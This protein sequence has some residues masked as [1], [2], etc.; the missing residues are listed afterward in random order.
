MTLPLENHKPRGLVADRLLDRLVDGELPN[1][2]RR[3]L[4]LRLESEPDGWRRC[5]LAF[6]ESQSWREA[7]GPLA[8]AAPI[9]SRPIRT[10]RRRRSVARLTAVAASLA[11]AFALGWVAHRQPEP[12]AS[13]E[14]A[15]PAAPA[16]SPTPAPG[17][18][19]EAA[20]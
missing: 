14:V 19:A 1:A 4:L 6:L 3:A 15:T 2:E 18:L 8:A 9:P 12:R 20:S 17:A 16:E 7:V 11:A 5:A 10:P 13:F